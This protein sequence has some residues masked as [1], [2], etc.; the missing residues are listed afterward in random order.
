MKFA[1]Y[2]FSKLNCH[3]QC[4]RKFKYGYIDRAPKDKRDITA[5]LK[6]GAVHSILE[7]FPSPSTHKLAPKY[8]HIADKF[9]LTNLGQKYLLENSTRE[10][11]FGLT[12]NFEPTGYSS[13]D[14]MFR[15]S[16]DFMCIINDVLNLIDWKTGKYKEPKWQEFTQLMLYAIYFFVCYPSI[17]K[18]R[19]SYVYIEHENLENELIL[20]RKYLEN[21]KSDLLTMIDNAE[22]DVLFE[23]HIGPLCN[24]CDFK[25]HCDSDDV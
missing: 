19:V 8:Q 24:Y 18:I 2:S 15:G 11:N 5:L 3:V 21:Y 16:V 22:N 17:N 7:N 20:E 9:I 10:F 4:N 1:P 25:T 12:S 6:G 14:A 23:K 13:K